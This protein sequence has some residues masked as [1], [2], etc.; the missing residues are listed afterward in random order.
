MLKEP[1]APLNEPVSFSL[2]E[3]VAAVSTPGATSIV[4]VGTTGRG[5]ARI[6]QLDDL[7]FVRGRRRGFF[8]DGA[9]LKRACSATLTRMTVGEPKNVCR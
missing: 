6:V 2:N 7:R 3:P 4:T 5:G 8:A 9:S 1:V